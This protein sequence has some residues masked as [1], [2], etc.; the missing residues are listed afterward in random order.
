MEKFRCAFLTD[1]CPPENIWV[2][3]PTAGNCS[4]VWEPVPLVDYYIAFIKR[5][6]GTEK[7]CNTTGTMCQFFCTCGYTYLTTV[8]PYNLAG[9]S[10][11]SHVRNYTTSRSHTT[12]TDTRW[13][14]Q[15]CISILLLPLFS[16]LPVPCCPD[17][18][19]INLVSTE[20]LEVMWS[21]VKGAEQYETTAEQTNDVIHCNDTAPVCALSDLTCNTAYSVTVT[22]CN[23]L[24]GCNRTCTSHTHQTGNDAANSQQSQRGLETVIHVCCC[25]PVCSGDPE[26]DAEQQLHI[27]SLLHVSQQA[28]H[29]LHRHCHRTLRQTHLPDDKRLL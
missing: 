8:F 22:P 10:P 6:D 24:R 16:S 12:N 19:T 27:Q 3:E 18:V 26:P 5:D 1:P 14:P 29:Q 28:Q 15:T 11:Y 23:D 25:S 13:F 20:T 4:V 9:S 2:E 21:A 17:D 7:S